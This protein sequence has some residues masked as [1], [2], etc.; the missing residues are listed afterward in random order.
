MLD[1]IH[2]NIFH[3][4][5]LKHLVQLTICLMPYSIFSLLLNINYLCLHHNIGKIYQNLLMVSYSLLFHIMYLICTHI[6]I[7]FMNLFYLLLI[8]LFND[9]KL[10]IK[11]MVCNQKVL[12]LTIM[13]N[14]LLYYIQ[15]ILYMFLVLLY[16]M[17]RLM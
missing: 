14:V 9:K 2:N 16:R 1:F 4:D 7:K 8:L 10:N 11:M 3:L 15:I 6:Q 5:P 12:I 17:F 13:Y